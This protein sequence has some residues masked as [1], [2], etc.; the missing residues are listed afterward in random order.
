MELIERYIHEVGRFLP[1]K[2]RADIQAELRSLLSESLESGGAGEP[3]EAAVIEALKKFGSPRV[4]ATRYHPE[5]QYLVGPVLYPFFQMIIGIVVAA[6]AGSQVIAWLVGYFLAG[7]I[8]DPLTALAGLVASI[9]AAVGWVVVVFY[10]LQ[11]FN[12]R[13]DEPAE[14][15]NPSELPQINPE[16]EIKRGDRITSIIFETILLAF[17]TLFPDRIGAYFFP[18]GAFFGNPVL[19]QY[20][21][22]ISLSLLVSI[23]LDVYLVWQGRWTTLNRLA[24]LA[25]NL[26]SIAVLALLVQGHTAWLQAHGVTSF[27]IA[28]Q[29]L[30]EDMLA[31]G[32]ILTIWAFWLAFS[33][34]LIVTILETLGMIY[35]LGRI[36]LASV[37]PVKGLTLPKG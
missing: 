2:N 34:A 22:W 24:L 3:D 21:V 14:E 16:E 7:E 13:P 11:R 9:P 6:V 37:K 29:K 20:L 25:A 1:A 35:R 23:A 27:A 4:V 33:V 17:L 12:V 28:M 10:F 18:N 26:F 32:Q 30:G 36:Y 15:W 19:T 5:G 8:F 31:N